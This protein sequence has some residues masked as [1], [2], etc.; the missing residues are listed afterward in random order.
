MLLK[1]DIILLQYTFPVTDEF[2]LFIKSEFTTNARNVGQLN[3]RTHGF[4]SSWTIELFQGPWE[5]SNVLT[6]IKMCW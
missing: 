1:T 3:R 5:F 4:V 2:V 6:N